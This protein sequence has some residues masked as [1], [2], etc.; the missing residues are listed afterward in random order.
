MEQL[1]A[2]KDKQVPEKDYRTEAIK[3]HE[4]AIARHKKELEEFSL[5]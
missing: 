1:K 2:L 5:K 3:K 4:E